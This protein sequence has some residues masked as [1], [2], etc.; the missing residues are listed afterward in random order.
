MPRFLQLCTAK[1]TEISQK[2]MRK[3]YFMRSCVCVCE[4]KY[5]SIFVQIE[6]EAKRK[7]IFSSKL[8]DDNV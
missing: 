2:K 5:D 4:G 1:Y 7:E 8:W 6:S 3:Y